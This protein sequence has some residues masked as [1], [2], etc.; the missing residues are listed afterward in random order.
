MKTFVTVISRTRW[1]QYSPPLYEWGNNITEHEKLKIKICLRGQTI[2]SSHLV[3][4]PICLQAC[5]YALKD[6]HAHSW[7]FG[8]LYGFGMVT[9][10]MSPLS[11]FTAHLLPVYRATYKWPSGGILSSCSTLKE[12]DL[13]MNF[14][15]KSTYL[16][17]H[18]W[19]GGSGAGNKHIFKGDLIDLIFVDFRKLS[20]TSGNHKKKVIANHPK[21]ILSRN[22]F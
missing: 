10:T 12:P 2:S 17:T 1:L 9:C 16:P 13:W 11:R 15:K 20:T 3:D 7:S 8:Q 21:N 6:S 4:I 18:R 14:E 22:V 19:N 5:A